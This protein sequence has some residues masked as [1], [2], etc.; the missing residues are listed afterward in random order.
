MH[1][2][3]LPWIVGALLLVSSLASNVIADDKCAIDLSHIDKPRIFVLTDIENEPDDAQSIARLLLYANQFQIEG[4]VAS[5]SFWLNDSVHP[6]KIQSIVDGYDAVL[7]NLKRHSDGWPDTEQLRK[8]VKA[9][10]PLYGMDGV[11]ETKDS[12]GSNLLID[13]VDASTEPLWVLVWGGPSILAQAL[14]RVE[15]TRTT[16]QVNEFV[17]KVRVYAISDQDNTGTWIRRLFPRLFYIASVHH[18]N[19]YALAAWAGMSGG[20]VTYFWP[21]GADPDI[22][23]PQW[24]KKNIQD[25]GPLGAKYPDT[26]YIAEGDTPSILYMIPNGLSDPE[27]P[28][29]GSW[30]G[31]YGPVNYGE[32]H[33]ADTVDTIEDVDGKPLMS[34]QATV[35]RWREAFQKDFAA[36]MRWTVK[37]RFEDANHVPVAVVNGSR[38]LRPVKL[39]VRVGE[40]VFLDASD[41]CDPDNNAT[42]SFKWWQYFEPSSTVNSKSRV[43]ALKLSS[44]S[45]STIEVH[46]PPQEITHKSLRGSDPLTDPQLHII[47]EVSDGEL[48]AYRRIVLNVERA[49]NRPKSNGS[50]ASHDEL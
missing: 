32:G 50:G 34:S 28:E 42:L 21:C 16:E 33:F 15:A 11:G 20:S 19:R 10:L 1:W 36:R 35:W 31:R 29:W 22:V 24:L 46:I 7:S 25:V 48:V 43:P 9:G 17:S 12:E 23:S 38:D 41:S 27:Y 45:S 13:A 37:D 18:F 30:G 49:W 2:L 14:W 26:E 44:N 4:L 47:L 3:P 8:R 5:T 40:S 39:N 6:E